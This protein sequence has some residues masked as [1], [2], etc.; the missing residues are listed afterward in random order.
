MP[1][2]RLRSGQAPAGIQCGGGGT[3]TQNLDSRFRG[4]DGTGSR[5]LIDVIEIPRLRAEGFLISPWDDE[6]SLA[7]PA[8]IV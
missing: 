8:S 4:K 2:L 3:E 5:L 1:A 6:K 7:I